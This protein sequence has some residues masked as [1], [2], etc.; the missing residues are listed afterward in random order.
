MNKIKTNKE[1]ENL[2]NN[3]SIS[4]IYFTGNTC[5]ACDVIK[6]KLSEIIKEYPKVKMGVINGEEQVKLAAD[7]SVF[8]LPLLILY[9]DGK[10]SFRVGRNFSVLEFMEVLDRYYDMMEL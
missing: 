2:I 6:G 10:E 5:M 1:I 4:L 8:S 7:Y 9:V 3:E